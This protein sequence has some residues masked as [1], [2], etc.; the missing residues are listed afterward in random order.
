MVRERSRDYSKEYFR[1]HIVSLSLPLYVLKDRVGDIGSKITLYKIT[2][3]SDGE[4]VD[5]TYVNIEEDIFEAIDTMINKKNELK[6]KALDKYNN[7]VLWLNQGSYRD[8]WVDVD[9][10][11]FLENE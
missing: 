2:E 11:T 3:E 10:Q 6:I 1:D 7:T 4:I 9:N 5:K 8:D